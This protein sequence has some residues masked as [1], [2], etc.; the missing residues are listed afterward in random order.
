MSA[1]WRDLVLLPACLCWLAA[2]SDGGGCRIDRPAD[3]PLIKDAR[4]PA[5]QATLDGRKVV[6]L[7]DTGARVSVVSRE[8][9]DLFALPLVENR[10]TLLSGINGTIQAPVA[11][12]GRLGLGSGAAHDLE[13]P[14]AGR[15]GRPVDG[16]PVLGL[17]GADFLSNYDV[18]LDVPSQRFAMYRLR[19]CGGRLQPFDGLAFDMPFDLVDTKIVLDLRLDGAPIRGVLDSGA[20]G[21]VITQDDARRA[22]VG[23]SDLLADRPARMI[24]ID[25]NPLAG[26]LHRFASLQVGA[27]QL[28]NIPLAVGDTPRTLL[29][30]DV[31]RF[32]RVWISYPRHLL[33]IQP[34]IPDRLR[35]GGRSSAAPSK[36]QL[37]Q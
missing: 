34:V 26:R 21:T 33:F 24:G 36:S 20:M 31:L 1:G 30:D 9:A 6:V 14:V 17:F 32:N 27:E 19:G 37:A 25:M 18:E 3:L 7:I 16:L 23:A 10:F 29:G 22:G 2:C 11:R 8:A 15:F 13:L 28:R 5:V 4:L 12:I 35:P